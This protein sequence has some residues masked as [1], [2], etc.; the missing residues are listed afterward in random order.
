MGNINFERSKKVDQNEVARMRGAHIPNGFPHFSSI[1]GRC[2]CL[3][4]CCQG[5]RGCKC[6]GC[7][8]QAIPDLHSE[9]PLLPL[10]S[11]DIISSTIMD[12]IMNG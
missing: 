8:C 9:S 5:E 1:T 12:G 4:S 6:K 11:E 3:D 7:P 2:M 10:I